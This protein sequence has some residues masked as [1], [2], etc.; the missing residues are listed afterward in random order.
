MTLKGL[1]NKI[2]KAYI[3]SSG[4]EVA[5]TT[6]QEG[7]EFDAPALINEM[8]QVVVFECEGVVSSQ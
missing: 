6:N 7:L 1:K 3:L 8:P 5:V 4:E 2:N